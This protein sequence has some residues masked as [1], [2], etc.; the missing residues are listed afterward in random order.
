[1]SKIKWNKQ[2]LSY[3]A[4]ST[5]EI[6]DSLVHVV[7]NEIDI[8]TATKE[9]YNIVKV[10]YPRWESF[11][12]LTLKKDI[13]VE[14]NGRLYNTIS[15]HQVEAHLNPVDANYLFYEYHPVDEILPWE[16]RDY[17]NP[18]EVGARVLWEGNV[19]ELILEGNA[20]SYNP[21]AYPQGWKLIP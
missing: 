3:I 18:Y 9:V 1:M 7:R 10:L 12:G 16:Q 6:L 2:K 13:I 20:Y 4:P 11:D 14:Y 19:Y 8:T 5:N 17:R 15:E 21:T